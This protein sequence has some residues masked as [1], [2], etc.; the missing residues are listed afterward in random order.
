MALP[1]LDWAPSTSK[2]HWSEAT[3]ANGPRLI[4]STVEDKSCNRSSSSL[5]CTVHPVSLRPCTA[6]TRTK[7]RLITSTSLSNP[8][9]TSTNTWRPAALNQHPPSSKTLSNLK[10]QTPS[11]YLKPETVAQQFWIP[12]SAR[13]TKTSL[14]LICMEAWDRYNLRRLQVSSNEVKSSAF[15]CSMALTIIMFSRCWWNRSKTVVVVEEHNPNSTL[16]SRYHLWGTT[17][18]P[19]LVS[20]QPN[21]WKDCSRANRV[22]LADLGDLKTVNWP[23]TCSTSTRKNRCPLMLL[24][25]KDTSRSMTGR[26]TI[27]TAQRAKK[28]I[29]MWLWIIHSRRQ[30]N[31]PAVS[32]GIESSLIVTKSCKT[33]MTNRAQSKSQPSTQWIR[34]HQLPQPNTK[35]RTSNNIS[36]LKTHQLIFKIPNEV[37]SNLSIICQVPH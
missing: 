22:S 19:V 14:V 1:I 23:N 21:N 20:N 30:K 8:T 27:W 16:I 3:A 26:S 25:T 28:P 32:L 31:S 34:T 18:I 2:L 10:S 12:N 11:S 29:H 15:Y 7:A 9:A 6:T 37:A 4:N 17:N 33:P 35:T 24:L 36:N 13:S 5:T